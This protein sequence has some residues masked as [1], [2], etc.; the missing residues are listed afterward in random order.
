MLPTGFAISPMSAPEA[1]KPEEVA[2]GVHGVH[3]YSLKISHQSRVI[4]IRTKS[5]QILVIIRRDYSPLIPLRRPVSSACATG[6]E[7]AVIYIGNTKLIRAIY[8]RFSAHTSD[9]YWFS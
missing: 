1:V 5:V 6:L 2:R 8:A 7:R 3:E 4:K 9:C